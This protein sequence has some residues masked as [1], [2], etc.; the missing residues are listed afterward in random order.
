MLEQWR[1]LVKNNDQEGISHYSQTKLAEIIKTRLFFM[2]R[3]TKLTFTWPQ[4]SDVA[5]R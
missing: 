2:L 5:S 3:S 4:R 1:F